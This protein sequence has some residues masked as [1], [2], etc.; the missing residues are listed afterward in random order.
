MSLVAG[1]GG[2]AR[3]ACV[4]V[5][6]DGQILGICEQ[7][8]ITRV[9]AAGFNS[10]GLPDEALDVLLRRSGRKKCEVTSYALAEAVPPAAA[11]SP[12]RL[13]H[14]FAHACSAFLPSP[15]QSATILVCDQTAPQMSVW[16]GDG[17]AL[18]RVEWSWH[19]P[20]FA[21]IYSRCAEA[22]GF[23]GT[24]REQRMEALARL[25]P[26]GHDDHAQELFSFD[27]D[28]LRL[29]P[30][31]HAQIESRVAAREHDRGAIA[32]GL[33]SRIADLLI[34]FL[35]EV[36]RR[37]PARRHLCIGGSL[38]NNSQ[39][40]SR[41]KLSGAFDEVF[42]PINPDDAGLA[43]GAAL[44]VSG[45]VRQPVTP[46]LGPAYS[47]EEIKA[48][49]DNC[50]LKYQWASESEAIAIAV[51][52]LQKGRLVGWFEGAM[53]WGPRALGAR[54]ILAS[55]FSQYV[56]E[57]LNRFLKQRDPWRGYALSGLDEAVLRHFDGPPASPFMECDYVPRDRSGFRHI[58][59]GPNAA[60]R[61]Q[62]VGSDAP[63]R[64]RGLLQAFGE[65]AGV[66]MLVNT[67]F[68]GFQEPIV[69]SPRDAVR[70]F[71]GTGIDLL[72]VGNFVIRK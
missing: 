69:C 19:G 21:E 35:A 3:N 62:T 54:S 23:T 12:V 45:D 65:G 66:P 4:A 13:E 26:T 55:P 47:P 43:V 11:H 61:I 37:A 72:V 31:W 14:H 63:P 15:F 70:V 56:L 27:T 32:A 6:A 40:N 22:L 60:V 48:T 42:I 28:R 44:H 8:R 57:N 16:D 18:N 51:D 17:S 38:F 5:C 36:K 1:L 7:E 41:V 20:G 71:F 59:P 52:A 50:K 2:A 64:F 46:F 33:Q 49:L 25:D 58:L 24:G 67:S 10:T 39:F 29:A 34:E 9:R 68:N 30:H 53:E